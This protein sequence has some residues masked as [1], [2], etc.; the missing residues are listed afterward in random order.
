VRWYD[1]VRYDDARILSTV[2]EKMKWGKSP[3]SPSTWRFDCEIHAILEYIYGKTLGY[4]EK[5]ELYSKMIREGSLER[6]EALKRIELENRNAEVNLHIASELLDRLG[7]SRFKGHLL[8]DAK[9][10]RT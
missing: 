2:S 9:T 4:T 10:L 3:D 1:Y 6:S 7:L 5:D 8:C